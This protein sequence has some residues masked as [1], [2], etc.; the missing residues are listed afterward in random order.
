MIN[1]WTRLLSLMK[2]LSPQYDPFMTWNCFPFSHFRK[3]RSFRSIDSNGKSEPCL[4]AEILTDIFHRPKH[5]SPSIIPV[6]LH[7]TPILPNLTDINKTDAPRS[8][9]Q[10][11]VSWG[12]DLD[13]FLCLFD[14]KGIVVDR[15]RTLNTTEF[16]LWQRRKD[17]E[18]C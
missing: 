2:T 12:L 18:V 9:A 16:T 3:N 10:K 8:Q 1:T 6:L 13:S 17:E 4:D 5:Y 15:K 11:K 7:Y 14:R